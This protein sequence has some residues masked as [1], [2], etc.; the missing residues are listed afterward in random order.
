MAVR[1][2]RS[3]SPVQ[4][5]GVVQL[6]FPPWLCLALPGFMEFH[7]KYAQLSVQWKTQKESLFQSLELFLCVAP[8]SLELSLTNSRYLKLESLSP[9]CGDCCALLGSHSLHCGPKSASRQE[10]GAVVGTSCFVSLFS[11]VKVLY[12]PCP[13]FENSRSI[14]FVLFSSCLQQK[15]KSGTS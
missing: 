9:H 10:A 14:H 13:I 4:V 8:F 6:S 5:L 7:H 3:P 2:W 12:Y 11:G 15:C 1:T